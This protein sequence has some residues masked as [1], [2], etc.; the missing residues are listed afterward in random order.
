M[1]GPFEF[2]VEFR[3][4][5]GH[6]ALDRVDLLMLNPRLYDLLKTRVEEQ[7]GPG[8]CKKTEGTG[9]VGVPRTMETC[10]WIQGDRTIE[11]DYELTRIVGWEPNVRLSFSALPEIR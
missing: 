11:L 4:R 2:S 3:S 9:I 6:G 5:G 7:Y 10:A 1:L 8:V